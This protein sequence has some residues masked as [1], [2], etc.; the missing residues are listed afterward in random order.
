MIRGKY[1]EKRG[2]WCS[3]EVRE[4]HGVGLWKGIRMN[5]DFV[6]FR[7]LFLVG[8]GRRVRFWR[9]RWC[10]DSPLYV[11]FP[12]LFALSVDKEAW[13]A[14]IWDPLAQGGWGV[15]IPIFQE[16]SMIERWKR[17]K[18]SWSGFMGRECREMWMIWCFGLKQRVEISWSSPST[19]F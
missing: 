12:S 7:I 8:N 1:G 19:L 17:R 2:G 9:D 10:G 16:P 13:V 6:G 11:S 18:D 15:G 3:R 4:A 5:W 14:D